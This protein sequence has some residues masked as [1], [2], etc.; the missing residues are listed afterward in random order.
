ML[1]TETSPLLRPAAAL[2]VGHRRRARECGYRAGTAIEQTSRSYQGLGRQTLMRSGHRIVPIAVSIDIT[3]L[4]AERC[5]FHAVRPSAEIAIDA[6]GN[7]GEANRRTKQS[8]LRG[9]KPCDARQ[10]MWRDDPMTMLSRTIKSQTRRAHCGA[11]KSG[12]RLRRIGSSCGFV[13]LRWR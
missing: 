9:P 7:R 13:A 12:L 5:F 6:I 11:S 3:T 2:P 4:K 10:L 1:S 8:F